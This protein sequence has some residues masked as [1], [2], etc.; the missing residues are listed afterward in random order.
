MSSALA[1]GEHRCARHAIA[2]FETRWLGLDLQRGAGD[3]YRCEPRAGGLARL[4]HDA[5]RH[6]VEFAT[7]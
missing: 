3:G 1:T 5:A 6:R 7:T 2:R 4:G